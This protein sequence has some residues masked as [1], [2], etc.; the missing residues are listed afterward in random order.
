MT[1]R[2]TATE[3]QLDVLFVE[4]DSSRSSYQALSKRF[5][6]IETPTW[7]LLL[8]QSCRAKGF[9]VAILDCNAERLDDETAVQRI[10]EANP[11][12]VCFVLYGQNPNSSTAN[13]AGSTRLCAL[14]RDAHPEHRTCFVGS[15]VSA[16]PREVLGYECI[17]FVLLNEGVYALH[18]LLASDL[19]T[20]LHKIRG[21]GYRKDGVPTLNP[22]EQVVPQQRLDQDLPGYA[23]DLLPYD[24]KPLDLYRAHF[25]HAEFDHAKTTP[26]AAVY[27]SLGCRFGCEFCMINI[28]NR[29]DNAD[30]ISASDSRLMRFWSPEFMLNQL[31]ELAKMGAE[32]VRFSD[33]MF[34]LNRRYFEPLLEGIVERGM[35]FRLWAYSRVDTVQ[36]RHLELFRKAGVGWLA[37]GIEAANQEVRRQVTKGSFQE[38]NIATVLQEVQNADINVIANYIFGLPDEDMASMERTLELAL[39]LN[40]EMANMYPCQALPGSQLHHLARERGWQLPSS[41]DGYAFLS[42]ECQPLPTKHLTAA[43]VLR[44]R[45]H[46]WQTYFTHEPYLALVERKF[47]SQ[48]RRNVEE[49]A[50][51]PMKRKI[52]GD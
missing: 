34:F 27:T 10:R 36:E 19:E 5:S 32:T 52:L 7:S 14:L 48:Q 16:L 18:N 35:Q 50:S 37:L 2:P 13:M 47:G 40:S 45:D 26:F 4:A 20:D 29:N 33:E 9:G 1:S 3:R 49:M 42:Y 24:E 17:D 28:L 43:E 11:R 46:A 8:A 51:V 12:L 6:A 39:E 15:H 38:V 30:H 44:F 21:I 23:W 31:E 22:P 41:Y 25:W